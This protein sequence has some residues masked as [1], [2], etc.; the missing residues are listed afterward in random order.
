MANPAGLRLRRGHGGCGS[1]SDRL[2]ALG[3]R[4]LTTRQESQESTPS[5]HRSK[6]G[7]RE[8]TSPPVNR[9]TIRDTADAEG[10]TLGRYYLIQV[11]AVGDRIQVFVDGQP[12]FDV[13]DDGLTAGSVALYSGQNA[14]TQ[15][16]DVRVDD[17]RATAPVVYRFNFTASEFTDLRHHVHSYPGAVL[18]ATLVDL[19]GVAAAIGQGVSIA[20]DQW[21]TEAESR[22]YDVVATKALGTAAPQSVGR[23]DVTRIKE[24]GVALGLLVRTAAERARAR[25]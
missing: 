14:G 16:R 6:L 22:A 9:I 19:A 24:N 18:A 13:R 8:P 15:F 23:F 5:H 12:V 3:G 25:D 2:G 1:G 20:V 17:L 21:P 10:A 11:E 7:H 4:S